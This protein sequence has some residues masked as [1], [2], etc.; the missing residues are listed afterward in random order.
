MKPVFFAL[1]ALSL[2]VAACNNGPSYPNS[3]KS[4]PTVEGGTAGA[5]YGDLAAA[6][7]AFARSDGAMT[8]TLE[9]A[10]WIRFEPNPA[11][12]SE[13]HPEYFAGLT[14]F[15]VVLLTEHFARP[16]DEDYLL[17]DSAGARV[18]AK[19][20]SYTADMKTGFGPRNA[21]AFKLVFKHT[22][23]KSVR[24]L[25]LTRAGEGGGKVMWE[26]PGT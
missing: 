2:T 22:M 15:D 24:W 4:Q 16:T 5:A 18:T 7:A 14:T 19:P 6:R 23:S 20:V 21:A 11:A 9:D 3:G 26:F 13:R 17:E 8:A 12:A 25:R 1:V 10:A